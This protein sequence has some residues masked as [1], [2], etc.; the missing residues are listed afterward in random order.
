MDNEKDFKLKNWFCSLSKLE[1]PQFTV[2]DSKT[3][4]HQR[5]KLSKKYHPD[6]CQNCGDTMLEI[7]SAIDYVKSHSKLGN[8]ESQNRLAKSLEMLFPDTELL[9]SGN[10]EMLG[11]LSGE[12]QNCED[13]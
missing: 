12:F 4:D 13:I 5:R 11:K 3:L 7:N 9:F 10:E 1:L 2:T 6:K 8:S